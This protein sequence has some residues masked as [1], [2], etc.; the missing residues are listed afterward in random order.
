[1]YKM[2]QPLFTN[3]LYIF[4]LYSNRCYYVCFRL[5]TSTVCPTHC[6]FLLYRLKFFTLRDIS[7]HSAYR[8]V[9]QFPHSTKKA[10]TFEAGYWA[11]STLKS[12]HLVSIESRVRRCY[13]SAV[14]LFGQLLSPFPTSQCYNFGFCWLLNYHIFC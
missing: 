9:P 7:S 1:M 11:W 8:R 10:M 4:M 12:P 13:W 14:M 2:V 3:C 5:C 6:Y